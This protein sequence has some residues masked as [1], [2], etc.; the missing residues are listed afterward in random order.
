MNAY[1]TWI[2]F[3]TILIREIRRFTRIWV[4]T[5]LPPV[6]TMALYFVIFGTLIGSRIGEM[7]GFSYMQFVVPGLIMMSVLTNA[8]ANVVSSFYGNKFQRSIEEQLIAPIPNWVILAG[9]IAGGVAR[10]LC[11]GLIVTLLSLFFTHLHIQHW[12]V[13]VSVVLLTSILF[14]LAGLINAVYAKSFD[15]ISIIPTFVLTPLTYL[16]GVFYS[17]N[18]LPPFWQT[19]L[20]DQSNSLYGE[21]IPLRRTRHQRCQYPFCFWN[22]H[23]FYYRC[24]CI[25]DALAEQRPGPAQLMAMDYSQLPLGK[26]TA[27]GDQYDASLLVAVPRSHTRDFWHDNTALPFN[28]IDNWTG[29]EVSWLDRKGKPHVACLLLSYKAETANIVEIK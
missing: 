10:G 26:H 12:G 3:Q 9:Y 1:E 7:G 16:G 13:M 17:I 25:C 19:C 22:D 4:Q 8:Y 23:I 15:D 21:C 28:G 20:A 18:L 6:I 24:R 11:I 29:Y 14:S 27:Y 2:A 5:L